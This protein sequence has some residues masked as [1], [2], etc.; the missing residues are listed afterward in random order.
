M[1]FRTWNMRVLVSEM[2]ISKEQEKEES[3]FMSSPLKPYVP[4]YRQLNI[5]SEAQKSY[6]DGSS[7]CGAYIMVTKIFGVMRSHEKEW[8]V[9]VGGDPKTLVFLIQWQDKPAKH[10]EK[11]RRG[12][13]KLRDRVVL[14]AKERVFQ[15]KKSAL[16]KEQNQRVVL[17]GDKENHKISCHLEM[18]LV[19]RTEEFFLIWENP[20]SL[21]LSFLICT[22]SI[23]IEKNSM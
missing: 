10:S 22:I 6:L 17:K 1:A 19:Q 8:E 20:L 2:E 4:I 13:G 11:D 16:T 7:V 23:E 14:K 12:R 9:K 5:R 18:N 3:K 15:W 21:Y